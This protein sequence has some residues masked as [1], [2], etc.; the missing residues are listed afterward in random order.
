MNIANK[1]TLL[2]ICAIPVF[3]VFLYWGVPYHLYI[4]AGIFIAASLTDMLDGYLARKY[5][6]IT[7]FGKFADPIADKLLVSAAFIGFI[8]VFS[9]PSWLIF[10]IIAREF[11]V[12]GLRIAAMGEGKVI[13]ANIWGKI[14]TATQMT[15][16]I[17]ILLFHAF[18]SPAVSLCLIGVTASIT[19]ISG[20]VYIYEN[21]NILKQW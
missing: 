11:I 1:V 14:K 20:V 17:I 16:I 9:V 15:V 10:I 12:T 6:L 7:T 3:L 2:R 19:L 21:R 5:N 8:D 13:A 4:A 18:L